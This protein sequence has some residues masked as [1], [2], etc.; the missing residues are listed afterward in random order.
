MMPKEGRGGRGGGRKKKD[1]APVQGPS[2]LGQEAL[3]IAQDLEKKRKAR[4]E[5]EKKI[6]E[7]ERQIA[8]KNAE[9][10]RKIEQDAA[11]KRYAARVAEQEKYGQWVRDVIANEQQIWDA[12]TSG[13]VNFGLA[14]SFAAGEAM[15]AGSS[16]QDFGKATV[17]LMADF[18]STVA[19]ALIAAGQ[20]MLALNTGNP[21]GMIAGGLALSLAAGALKAYANKA[22]PPSSNAASKLQS[23]ADRMY[24]QG[25][26]EREQRLVQVFLGDSVRPTLQQYVQDGINRRTI[27]PAPGWRN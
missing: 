13:V 24:R 23:V 22:S 3:W 16:I 12:A 7:M 5:H 18:A 17:G 4:L 20:G 15:V 21:V 27:R 14:F 11:D 8:L 6:G 19:P 26:D 25:K 2:F 1:K 9:H 10:R